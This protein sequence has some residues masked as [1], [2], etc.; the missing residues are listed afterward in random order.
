MGGDSD[1][2]EVL[3]SGLNND[4]EFTLPAGENSKYP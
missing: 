3:Y 4:I 1:L 2:K